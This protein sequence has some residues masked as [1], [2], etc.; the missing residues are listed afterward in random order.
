MNDENI[1]PDGQVG[2]SQLNAAAPAGTVGSVPT[3]S[4][5]SATEAQGMTLEELNKALGKQFPNRETALKSI[6]DTFSYVGKKKEDIEKEV[7]AGIQNNNRVDILARELEIERTERFYDR[8]PQ[9]ASPEVRRFIE[10]TG[11]KPSD[12]VSSEDFKAIFNKVVEYDKSVKL[13]TVL[14]SNPRLSSSR[15]NIVKA[16]E[17]LKAGNQQESA[18]AALAA[19]KDLLA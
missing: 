5:P 1:I 3:G 8:N 16:R 6:K 9:Y 13:K 15:D 14:E 18:E 19:V 11:K 12:V 4:A 17:A 7:L 10:S 2:A